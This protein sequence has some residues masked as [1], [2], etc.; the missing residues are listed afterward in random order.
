M[1]DQKQDFVD[2]I[3]IK[4]NEKR[5]EWENEYGEEFNQHINEVV[6]KHTLI[7]IFL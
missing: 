4:I 6:N 2:F 1:I 5:D 7:K 3:T